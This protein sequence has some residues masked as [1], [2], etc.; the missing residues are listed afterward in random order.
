V[1]T[2]KNSVYNEDALIVIKKIE[3]DILY[4]DPPYNVRQ[5]GADYHLLNT[6]AIYDEFTPQGKTG[7]REY[8]RSS[9]CKKHSVEKSLDELIYNA[10]FPYIFMSYSSD[11]ILSCKQIEMIMRKYGNYTCKSVEHKRFGRKREEIIIVEYLH[12][13]KKN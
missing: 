9:F 11:G 4:L 2:Q 10:K 12:I 13:L 7:R 5:Y 3:G 6:I 8:H 1:S